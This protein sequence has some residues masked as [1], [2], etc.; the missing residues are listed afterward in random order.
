MHSIGSSLL[1]H[2]IQQYGEH[3]ARCSLRQTYLPETFIDASI[4]TT[5]SDTVGRSYTGCGAPL[6]PVKDFALTH[7]HTMGL[8]E[9]DSRSVV[10]SGRDRSSPLWS[11]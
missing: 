4:I 6:S 11:A 9:R 1:A 5:V 10:A 8:V 2:D 3:L 7:T